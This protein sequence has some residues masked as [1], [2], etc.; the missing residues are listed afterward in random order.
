M[1]KLLQQLKGYK[2]KSICR[3]KTLPSRSKLEAI[4][5]VL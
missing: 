4:D 5:L 1:P 3:D 2:T